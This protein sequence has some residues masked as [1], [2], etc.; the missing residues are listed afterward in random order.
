MS[1]MRLAILG[2]RGI[3]NQY[4]GFEQAA[5]HLS[6]R[7]AAKGHQVT[8]YNAHHHP[9]K[10]KSWNN[11]EIV[12]CYDPEPQTGTAGQFIYDFNCIRHARRRGYD[13]ILFMGYTSSSVWGRFYPHKTMVVSN[14]DGLE[15]KRSKYAAAVRK[16]L[17]MAEKWAIKFSDYYISDSPA[18]Q[19]YL[20]EK[21]KAES[22]FIPYGAEIF[23][24]ANPILLQ[25]YQISAGKYFLL[26]ARM[27]PENNI[28]TI[29]DGYIQ[30]GSRLPIVVVGSTQNS[31]GKKLS[32]KYARIEGIKFAGGIFD[33]EILQALRSNCR[34]YFH[35]HSVG[36]TNP[37]LLEAMAA[38]ALISAHENPFNRA[39]LGKDAFYF[40]S[41]AG[42]R[43]AILDAATAVDPERM[44]ENNLEKI[45]NTYNW[46]R[47]ADQ[48]ESYLLRCLQSG[49]K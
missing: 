30:S 48:Y 26:I 11:V 27:E 6:A 4:G 12:H 44:Q 22:C 3:P 45:K 7:L 23:P 15:W 47:V 29:L 42:I 35:G 2:T 39:V 31:Y 25:P 20:Q 36:G 14:M 9:F 34:L 21:Y 1:G 32:R 28:A 41:V 8:V 10:A 16:Y 40:S 13:I 49:K 33:P 17:K 5:M 46:D 38:G 24:P 37:S 19:S 43:Q 18:I